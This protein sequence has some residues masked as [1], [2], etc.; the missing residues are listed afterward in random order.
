M[1]LYQDLTT[2]NELAQLRFEHTHI[3]NLLGDSTYLPQPELDELT[4]LLAYIKV[5]TINLKQLIK[6]N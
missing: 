5:R 4:T 1:L 3:M 2:I 6:D